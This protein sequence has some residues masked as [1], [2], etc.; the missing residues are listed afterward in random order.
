MNKLDKF[1]SKLDKKTRDVVK[2]VIILIIAGELFT[3]DIKKLKGSNDNYRV[4][5]GRI[6]IIFEQTPKGSVIKDISFRSD[7]TY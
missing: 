6:R 1:L 4:R 2:R 3:L 7:N 5:V